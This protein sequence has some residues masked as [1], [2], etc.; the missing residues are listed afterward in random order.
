MKKIVMISLILSIMCVFTSQ[1]NADEIETLKQR[2]KD[3]TQGPCTNDFQDEAEKIFDAAGKNFSE[4]F[5]AIGNDITVK[6]CQSIAGEIFYHL[7]KIK[8]YNNF[9][10]VFYLKKLKKFKQNRKSFDRGEVSSNDFT[11][12][13]KQIEDQFIH[14]I[15]ESQDFVDHKVRR[16]KELCQN[17]RQNLNDLGLSENKQTER[18]L[19]LRNDRTWQ[20]FENGSIDGQKMIKAIQLASDN[21]GTNLISCL[22]GMFQIA[23]KPKNDNIFSKDATQGLDKN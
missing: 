6:H 11:R 16:M 8:S 23:S 17:F 19:Y 4:D 7:D 1:V 18:I 20:N 12:V 15:K 13:S 14:D 10:N 22:K 2:L 9:R 3:C 21:A 5:A